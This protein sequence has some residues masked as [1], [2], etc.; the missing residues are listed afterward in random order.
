MYQTPE[1]ETRHWFISHVVLPFKLIKSDI[2]ILIKA[3]MSD[4]WGDHAVRTAWKNAAEAWMERA[5]LSEVAAHQNLV[6]LY[7]Q[8]RGMRIGRE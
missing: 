2:P 7:G 4:E 6:R 3:I 8:I 5:S 1:L